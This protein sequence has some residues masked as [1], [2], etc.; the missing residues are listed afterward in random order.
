MPRTQWGQTWFL[1]SQKPQS[2]GRD[3]GIS[4]HLGVVYRHTF[5]VWRCKGEKDQLG[6]R[7]GYEMK[8]KAHSTDTSKCWEPS[9]KARKSDSRVVVIPGKV[10]AK[11]QGYTENIGHRRMRCRSSRLP[12]SQGQGAPRSIICQVQGWDWKYTDSFARKLSKSPVK[13]KAV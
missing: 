10:I 7:K 9:V 13:M 6:F 4:K 1:P 8:E 2:Y 11:G 5:K 3:R 12:T